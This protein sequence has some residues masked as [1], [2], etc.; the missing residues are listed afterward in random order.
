M[1]AFTLKVIGFSRVFYEGEAIQL[2]LPIQDGS[3]GIMAHHEAAVIGIVPGTLRLQQPDG[4]W[5]TA[6]VDAGFAHNIHII[7]AVKFPVAQ[8]V[9]AFEKIPY[10]HHIELMDILLCYMIVPVAYK[11]KAKFQSIYPV[12]LIVLRRIAKHYTAHAAAVKVNAF[13]RRGRN[14]LLLNRICGIDGVLRGKKQFHR[15]KIHTCA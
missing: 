1:E 10:C 11:L 9:I 15:F 4:E 7:M 6:V 2:Q 5:Q 14:D 13:D 8:S 3:M 12:L